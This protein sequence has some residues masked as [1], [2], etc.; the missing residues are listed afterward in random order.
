MKARAAGVEARW[1]RSQRRRRGK[2]RKERGDGEK[3]GRKGEKGRKEGEGK[4]GG[5][6]EGKEGG[7]GRRE[8]DGR[9]FT[10]FHTYRLRRCLWADTNAIEQMAQKLTDEYHTNKLL[11][12][13][14]STLK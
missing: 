14:T 4:E 5:R 6:K 12:K 3:E 13:P 7:K 1:S 2:L 8:R 9:Q 10:N 11:Q